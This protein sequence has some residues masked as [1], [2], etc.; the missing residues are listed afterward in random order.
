MS[1]KPAADPIG[2]LG[3]AIGALQTVG[4]L[5]AIIGGIG[6]VHGATKQ[7]SRNEY[8]TTQDE[9]SP[10]RSEGGHHVNDAA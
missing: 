5:A 10:V 9:P 1:T 3:V 6:I 8:D 2:L 4:S 7:L